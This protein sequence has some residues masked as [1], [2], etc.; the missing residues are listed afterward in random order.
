MSHR[1]SNLIITYSDI[2]NDHKSKKR[3]TTVPELRRSKRIAAKSNDEKVTNEN[4][5]EDVEEDENDSEDVEDGENEE[6]LTSDDEEI[7]NDEEIEDENDECDDESAE[8][9]PPRSRHGGFYARLKEIVSASFGKKNGID[10]EYAHLYEYLINEFA[11]D[12]WFVNLSDTDKDVYINKLIDVQSYKDKIPTVKEILDMEIEDSSKKLLIFERKYL[13]TVDMLSEQYTKDCDRFVKM[14]DQKLRNEP[15]PNENIFGRPK[16]S[17]P[18]KERI[19]E[20]GFSNDVKAVIY[21]KYIH[22]TNCGPDEKSKYQNWIDTV[23]SLPRPGQVKETIGVQ[24]NVPGGHANASN[25]ICE[26]ANKFEEKI[27]GLKEVKEEILGMIANMV[28]NPKCK[29]KAIGMHGPP[30]IGKTMI[31]KIVSEVLGVPYVHIALGGVTD[32]SFLEGHG[33]TYIGSEPGAIVKALIEMK[34]TNGI[35]FFDEI[36]K[37]SKTHHGKEVEHALLHITD[38]TQNHNYRDKYVGEIPIDLSNCIFIC[39]M[40]STEEIDTAL[41]SRIP[42]IKF[43]GYTNAEKHH[44]VSKYIFPEILAEYNIPGSDIIL[45]DETIRHAICRVKEEG[46]RDDKSGVRGI[47]QFLNRLVSKINLCRLLHASSKQRP[48]FSFEI[49]NF[50]I[51]YTITEELIDAVINEKPESQPFMKYIY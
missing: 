15:D 3:K 26:M 5:S 39:A 40:N 9:S 45:T 2:E 6:S 28:V 13:D 14:V 21:D 46:H 30:G 8:D 43:D 4:E 11:D 44:I 19:L 31:V 41:L 32:S 1:D 51:P 27:Y 18:L 17:M 36:D 49:P 23:L 25:L 37:I 12:A 22:Y 16:I 20:S 10:P 35:I 42:L 34:Q 33:F 48:A 50:S 24:T 7:E 47:K 38:F 29:N